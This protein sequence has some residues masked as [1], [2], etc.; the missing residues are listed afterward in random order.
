MK[1]AIKLHYGKC[2]IKWTT[3]VTK[4]LDILAFA[5]LIMTTFQNK[6]LVS[7]PSSL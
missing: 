2:K 6:M 3:P 7:P 1:T 4:S 5:V